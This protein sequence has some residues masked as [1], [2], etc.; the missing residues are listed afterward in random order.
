MDYRYTE[1]F[2]R[3]MEAAELRAHGLRREAM[4]QFW[5]DA[6]RWLRHVWRSFFR[7]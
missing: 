6:A 3:R 1:D 2:A 7:N 5:S 4:Q